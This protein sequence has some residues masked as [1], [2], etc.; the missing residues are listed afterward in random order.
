M[1]VYEF[2]CQ[3]CTLRF[4]RTLKMDEHTS[5]PCPKCAA[6]AP[7]LWEGFGGHQFA[8]GGT[9]VANS[10]VHDHDYPT[11]DKAVGRNSEQRWDEIEAREKV[12]QAVREGGGTR[13]LARRNGQDFVEYTA[14][15]ED[16]MEKRKAA[17]KDAKTALSGKQ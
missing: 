10:G 3:E 12:K 16:R 2:E 4:K 14:M 13:A 9:A 1:P 5:H 17:Y 15:T 7:R 11:A 6:D 8:P